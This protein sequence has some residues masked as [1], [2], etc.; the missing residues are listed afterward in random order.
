M[1]KYYIKR[2]KDGSIEKIAKIVEKESSFTHNQ[3]PYGFYPYGINSNDEW[4]FMPSLA[5]IKDGK[6]DFNEATNDETK[7]IEQKYKKEYK[8]K[9]PLIYY[10]FWDDHEG[11]VHNIVKRE[12]IKYYSYNKGEWISD[13]SLGKIQFEI[14]DYYEISNE[15]AARL[16]EMRDRGEI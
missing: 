4:E 16:I 8:A 9:M 12:G 10:A 7:K 15:E 2:K 13:N 6:T 11:K 5:N 14:T 1:I 3:T